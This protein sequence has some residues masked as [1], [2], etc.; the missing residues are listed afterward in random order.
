M[1]RPSWADGGPFCY[2]NDLEKLAGVGGSQ[3]LLEF[4]KE[5][6]Q[7]YSNQKASQKWIKKD[8]LSFF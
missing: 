5:R 2:I 4:L 8:F 7:F 3:G 6:P 1:P